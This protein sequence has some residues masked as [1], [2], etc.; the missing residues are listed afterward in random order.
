MLHPLFIMWVLFPLAFG[1][2][3]LGLLKLFGLL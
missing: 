2:G 1:L 3:S